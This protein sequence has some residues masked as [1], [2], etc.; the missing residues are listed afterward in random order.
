VIN[1][2]TVLIFEANIEIHSTYTNAQISD[3]K[4]KND[5]PLPL[6]MNAH[7]STLNL[8]NKR[9]PSKNNTVARKASAIPPSVTLMAPRL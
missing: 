8:K 3:Y 4:G 6:K 7:Q 5:L 9:C 2:L 1:D